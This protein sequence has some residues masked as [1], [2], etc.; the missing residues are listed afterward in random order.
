MKDN[1]DLDWCE[2]G[3]QEDDWQFGSYEE[4]ELRLRHALNVRIYMQLM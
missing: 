1:E 2:P 3:H 4:I